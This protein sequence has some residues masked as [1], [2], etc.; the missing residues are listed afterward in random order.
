MAILEKVGIKLHHSEICSILQEN[1]IKVKD[2]I[3]YFTEEQVMAWVGK[4]PGKF[5]VYA[6][7]S[8]HDALIGGEQPQYVGGY[9]CSAIIDAAGNRRVATLSDYI[10]LIKLVQQCD[11]F[12]LNGGIL[13]QPIELPA[14]QTHAAMTYTTMLFSDKCIMGQPG[15]VEA[16]EKIMAMAAMAFGGREALMQK[17]RILTLVNPLSPMQIDRIALDTIKV[18]AEYGQPLV[19]TAGVM[20]GTT[21]PITPA[22]ALS[23]SNAE[24]LAAIAITQMLR[25]GTPVVM[26]VVV[27]PADMRSGGLNLGA[28]AYAI[29]IRYAKALADMYGI[30]CRCGGCGSDANGLTAQSGYESMINM[31]VSLQEKV[32]L[33]IH[34]AGILNSYSGMSFEKFIT[35]LEVVSIIEHHFADI[36]V[37]DN[38]LALPVIVETG[39]GGEFLTHSHT[40]A[41][42]R[43]VPWTGLIDATGPIKSGENAQEAY[44]AKVNRT[45]ERIMTDYRQPELEPDL[46]TSLESFLIEIGVDAKYLNMI[47]E[48]AERS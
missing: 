27:V 20:S 8:E 12:R 29:C 46:Q 45:L 15:P 24:A 1:G 25:E 3:A 21:A 41:Q 48:A 26:G 28:P 31:F 32:D 30:P 16:V 35:D 11:G 43:N 19:I 5:T 34:S 17:P 33:I 18:H 10:R 4:A 6:R 14:A 39:H 9:G 22:G 37:N 2:R 44:L 40:L 36:T 42:C 7:N 13:V 23:M 47:K 38:T